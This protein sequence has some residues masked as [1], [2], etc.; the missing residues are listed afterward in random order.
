MEVKVEG[1][2]WYADRGTI[3][4]IKAYR[5]NHIKGYCLVPVIFGTDHNWVRGELYWASH[6]WCRDEL[7]PACIL[8]LRKHGIQ[9]R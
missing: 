6:V 5:D 8:E 4:Q 7:K 9:S 3:I 1:Y 2:Y